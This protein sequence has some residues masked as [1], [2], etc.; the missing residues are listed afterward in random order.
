MTKSPWPYGTPQTVKVKNARATEKTEIEI[1]GQS[2]NVVEYQPERN[3]KVRWEQNADCLTIEAT[4]AQRIYNDRK[5]PNPVVIKITHAE[6][7]Q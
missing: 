6:V 3:P 2:G 5:W 7:A 4:R 1:L